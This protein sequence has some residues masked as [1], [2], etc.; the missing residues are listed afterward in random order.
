MS[1][2]LNQKQ[3]L[4]LDELELK[5][6]IVDEGGIYARKN[7]DHKN[8]NS[9]KEKLKSGIE[10]DPISVQPVYNYPYDDDEDHDLTIKTEDDEEKTYEDFALPI[11][12]GGGHRK[13]S[14]EEYNK[15]RKRENKKI[16]ERNKKIEEKETDEEKKDKYPA[17]KPNFKIA[18]SS[19]SIDYVKNFSALLVR[20]FQDN[21][22]Q[23]LGNRNS[24][25]KTVARRLRKENPEWSAKKI[26]NKLNRARPTISPYIENIV[27]RQKA[28]KKQTAR[29]FSRLGWTQKEV[30]EIVNLSRNRVSEIVDNVDTNKIDNLRD[31]GKDLNKICDLHDIDLQTL[32]SY[33]LE[34]KDDDLERAEE[35]GI[36]IDQYDIWGIGKRD[37]RM[38]HEYPGQIPGQIVLNTLT[39]FTEQSDLVV[40]PMAGGGVTNDACLMMNRRC[41]S[42]D[43]EP[44]RKDIR[45]WDITDGMP[46]LNKSVDLVF[47]DP[48]YSVKKADEY[49]LP[50]KYLT[51]EGFL[52]FAQSWVEYSKEIL[53]NDGKV[54]LLISDYKAYEDD[55]KEDDDGNIIKP[56]K[57]IFS[58]E[59]ANLFEQENFKRLYKISVPLSTQQYRADQVS[60]VKDK[61]GKLLMRGRELYILEKV[62]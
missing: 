42:Y 10:L 45:E 11:N 62:E 55:E 27:N 20:D 17:M 25:T 46:D 33:L 39:H 18:N 4:N 51:K 47:L 36:K 31:Q 14:Y 15:W 1:I 41:I 44:S 5:D 9:L 7:R 22:E 40:D 59:Y 38:G 19:T 28:S 61:K 58:D 48:P 34:D 32:W 35:L 16:E 26:G 60:D 30:G 37:K 13:V 29:R 23:G 56:K 6:V 2:D 21:D 43:K 54:A 52:D 12:A 49:E 8:I 24:D 50:D 3:E 57:S 53:N